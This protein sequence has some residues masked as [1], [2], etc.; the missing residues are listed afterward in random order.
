MSRVLEKN[1]DNKMGEPIVPP[2]LDGGVESYESLHLN[3][4]QIEMLR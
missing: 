2:R 1:F 3:Q 4:K